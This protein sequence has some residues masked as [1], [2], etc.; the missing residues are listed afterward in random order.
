[1]H[2]PTFHHVLL[3]DRGGCPLCGSHNYTMHIPF[4]AIPVVRCTSCGFIFS[5]RLMPDEALHRYYQNG[6]GSERHRCGQIINAKINCWAIQNLMSGMT[7]KNFLDVGAGYGFLLHELQDR[8]GVSVT[9]VEPS[10][11]EACY[12]SEHLNVDLR[13]FSLLDSGLEPSS[14]DVVACFEVLEHIPSPKAFIDELLRY[15]RPGGRLL[16]MTDNFESEVVTALGPG[17]PKWIPHSH[18]SHFGP[19][20]LERL[21]GDK[22]MTVERSI[23]YTPWELL[24]RSIYYK[25]RDIQTTP[26]D[27][28]DLSSTL[29]S[30][31]HGSYRF[32]LLRR[33]V[34]S[35]WARLTARKGLKGALMYVVARRND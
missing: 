10:E 29:E 6:F 34:N 26:E 5:A 24:V 32:Y 19:E 23:S 7:F 13:N 17:F 30:E 1:M 9:S 2:D 31:M 21:L 11:Q 33:V 8:F 3:V 25:I 20:S 18:V 14:F 28:F 27:A 12:G 15:L 22:G 16:V 35:L 4:T